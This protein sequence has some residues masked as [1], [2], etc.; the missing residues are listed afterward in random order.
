[1]PRRILIVDDKASMRDMLV[2]AFS[3]RG[4]DVEQASNGLDAIAI[5]ADRPFDVII[6]DLNM[7][8]ETGIGVL[9]AARDASPDTSV[10]IVT[11][12]G[13]IDTAVEAMRPGGA[14]LHQQA[15]QDRGTGTQDRRDPP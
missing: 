13:T 7:P 1:M 4:F 8:G 6:T 3:E 2:T 9:R 5:L 14:R 12:F 10:I 11:A 15:V